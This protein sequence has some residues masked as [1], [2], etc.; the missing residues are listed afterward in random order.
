MAGFTTEA[1]VGVFVLVGMALLAYMSIRVGGFDLSRDKGYEVYAIFDNAS[2]LKKD[3]PVE[4]AG[5]SV[6]KVNSIAL[7]NGKARI[8]LNINSEVPLA[9]D[10]IAMIR[11]KGVLGDK[12]VE[13]IPGSS[14][15][16]KLKDGE[17]IVQTR[18]PTDIDQIIAKVGEISDG[19][20]EVTTSLSDV[21]GGED[22]AGEL[23]KIIANFS[24]MSENLAKLTRDNNK[25]LE[26]MI[27]NLTLFSEDLRTMSQANKANIN[28]ILVSFAE[29]SKRMGHTIASLQE[30]SAKIN[31]GQGTIGAL[32]NDDVTVKK[33]NSTLA[34]LRDISEKINAGQGTLGK[35]VNDTTTADQLEEALTGVNKYLAKQDQFR[36]FVEY[37][38]E[39][40]FDSDDHKWTLN[41]RLQP[42]RTKYYLVGITSDSFGTLKTEEK[43]LT[44]NGV[45]TSWKEE[46]R[47]KGDIKFNAQIAKRFY[48]LVIRGGMIES[49]GGVGLDYYMYDDKLK[50]TLEAFTGDVDYN[51]HVRV[52]A[53]YDIWQYIF[54]TAGYDDIISNQG[55]SSPFFGIGL[56]F[57][58][59]DLKYL[60]SSA[61]IP[62]GN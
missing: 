57:N 33:L 10:C 38:S 31:R 6:G 61:P 18:T 34:S 27:A 28:A 21:L 23:R 55:R 22:G 50:F 45:T 9:M 56:H 49:G 8:N 53:Q 58:D 5:I 41:V 32:V 7:D 44:I 62:T 26:M 47:K 30:I 17:R 4:V 40:L 3:V 12:Y 16:P 24:E 25:Q 59:D 1:K 52:A 15:L 60:L 42:S 48:D 37:K 51:P 29:T 11:T 46:T 13:I 43:T 36:V 54:I 39:W 14:D 2:G 35:L 20:T 19:I